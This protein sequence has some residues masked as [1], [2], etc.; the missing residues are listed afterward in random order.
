MNQQ[1]TLRGRL[2]PV[3]AIFIVL[4]VLLLVGCDEPNTPDYPP[5]PPT[6]PHYT[7]IGHYQPPTVALN[8]VAKGNTAALAA[9][10]YGTLVL[11]VSDPNN[12]QIMY[13]DSVSPFS[14]S[15]AVGLDTL[16]KYVATGT[17]GTDINDPFRVMSYRDSTRVTGLIFSGPVEDFIFDAED[18]T[19]TFWCA[20]RGDGFVAQQF[21]RDS[22][23]A[24]WGEFC[25]FPFPPGWGHSGLTMRGFGRRADGVF[26]FAI[27]LDGIHLH[28]TINESLATFY[29]P[30]IANDCAWHGNYIIVADR[31]MLT[32]VNAD[33]LHS[34]YV[35]TTFLI[36]NADRLAKI[37]MD[38]SLAC[39][40]DEADGIYI[41]DFSN[42]LVPM[43]IEQISLPEPTSLHFDNG[44]LYVTDQAMG[45]LVYSR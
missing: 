33:S 32:V 45:L 38:G 21:C 9:S 19:I 29:T 12:V 14:Q 5:P 6:L 26:A 17:D 28:N 20:D 27:D 44:R 2:Y 13:R 24:P 18:D 7:L 8:V 23:G 40:M 39:V 43:L 31:L 35:A 10:S 36:H 30:G 11:N 4:S 16:H 1:L 41:V 3:V 25:N 15:T 37:V 34:P 22:S 42:P